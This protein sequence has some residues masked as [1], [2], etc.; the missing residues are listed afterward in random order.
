MLFIQFHNPPI[1]KSLN[2]FAS[3][4]IP[5]KEKKK[6]KK[7]DDWVFEHRVNG[8]LSDYR[9]IECKHGTATVIKDYDIRFGPIWS[10]FATFRYSL[11]CFRL[12]SF[13]CHCSTLSTFD[14]FFYY[15]GL[16]Y[17]CAIMVKNWYWKVPKS[18]RIK[19]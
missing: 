17:S 7:T 11:C 5:T 13:I 4:K 19:L 12:E 15:F 2:H 3:F 1:N 10:I 16:H 8:K 6:R 9:G 14:F 18:E